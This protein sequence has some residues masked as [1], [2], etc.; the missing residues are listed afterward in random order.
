M[1]PL[2]DHNAPACLNIVFHFL[3][4]HVL[5]NAAIRVLHR[6]FV[7]TAGHFIRFDRHYFFLHGPL[8]L[9]LRLT[10]RQ[11]R[12]RFLLLFDQFNAAAWHPDLLNFIHF[13]HRD[14]GFRQEGYRFFVH[15]GNESFKG[16]ESFKFVDQQ[17]VFLFI[18]SILN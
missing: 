3:I 14:I 13:L 7:I 8:L 2:F 11:Q 9:C 18:N 6:Y 10:S 17:R 5:H 16:F 12:L 15:L 1:I 4:F